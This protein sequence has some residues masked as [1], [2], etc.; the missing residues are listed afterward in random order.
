MKHIILLLSIC[1]LSA[2]GQY[3]KLQ[4]SP[5]YEY[6]YEAAKAYYF[7]GK[8]RNAAELL[9]DLIAIMKGTQNGEES[10]F[11]LGMSEYGARDFTSAS[12]YLQKY[13]QSYPKGIYTEQARFFSA[14]SLY[15]QIPDVRLDQTGTWDAIREFQS[16]VDFYP[17]SK[18]K[19]RAQSLITE[20]QDHLVE[21]EML[22]AKLYYDLGDYINNC[23]YGGSNYEACVVTA[24]NALKDFPFATTARREELSMLILRSKYQLARK[25]TEEKRID[26]FRSA[27]DEYYSFVNDFPESQFIDEA[28]RIFQNADAIVKRKKIKLDED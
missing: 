22:S 3:V 8:F 13:V 1:L 25:S 28:N 19:E 10:L 9:S 15:E 17:Y 26:R 2:C 16:F 24:E 20:M 11:L 21:K 12:S 27:I 4:K 14:L 7:Q 5:D 18:Y 23:L 6:R